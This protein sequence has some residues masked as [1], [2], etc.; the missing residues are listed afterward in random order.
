MRER[1]AEAGFTIIE[2]LVVITL[3]SLVALGALQALL[4]SR[5]GSE[6]ARDVVRVSEEARHAFNRLVRD[7]REA[8]VMRA[9][10]ETS[11]DVDVDFDRS[12]T[13]AQTQNAEGDFE[14][15]TYTY[16][17]DAK[18]ITLNGE[19]LAADV[20]QVGT[21]PV[22]S[23]SSSRLEYDWNS[24]GVT[25]W[26]ELNDGPSHGVG[27][28]DGDAPPVLDE[29]ELRLVD[30]VEVIFEVRVGDTSTQFYGQAQL[31]NLREQT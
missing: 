27:V 3:T 10:T 29:T 8:Q 17:P 7:T 1:A 13:I 21:T 30:V 20:Y 28:G 4:A 15:L 12:E 22:F 23:Y 14:K 5:E 18:Q 31:R 25:T 19:L 24:D 9:A 6:S 26:Q 11:F 2:L 16:D